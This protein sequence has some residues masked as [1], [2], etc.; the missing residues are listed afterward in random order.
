MKI[1]LVIDDGPEEW[2][3]SI[4]KAFTTRKKANRYIKKEKELDD[5]VNQYLAVRAIELE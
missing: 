2:G 5:Y 1:Y 3:W 4:E